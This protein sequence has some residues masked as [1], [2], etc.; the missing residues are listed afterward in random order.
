MLGNGVKGVCERGTHSQVH[1]QCVIDLQRRN[2]VGL[3]EMV[4]HEEFS[5][6]EASSFLQEALQTLL[7]THAHTKIDFL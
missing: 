2:V 1:L 5:V 7:Y 6:L 3:L 4:N